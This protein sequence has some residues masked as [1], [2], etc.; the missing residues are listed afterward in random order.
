MTVI[1]ITIVIIMIQIL[2]PVPI[3]M[4]TMILMT[5][6]PNNEAQ[7][8]LYK[9]DNDEGIG[10]MER[11]EYKTIQYSIEGLNQNL[12][13]HHQNLLTKSHRGGILICF[14]LL[15]HGSNFDFDMTTKCVSV[16]T[17]AIEWKNALCTGTGCRHS[18]TKK[19]SPAAAST[20]TT[21]TPTPTKAQD[22]SKR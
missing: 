7:Q 10:T 19:F 12:C 1:G 14:S 8:S 18:L 20:N 22:T 15:R 5:I 2:L 6:I 16:A 13:N 17:V 3:I 9:I 21:S 11:K 4:T